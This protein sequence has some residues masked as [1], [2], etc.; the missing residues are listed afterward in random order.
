MIAYVPKC[1]RVFSF[2]GVARS[3]TQKSA[4]IEKLHQVIENTIARRKKVVFMVFTR[5][6]EADGYQSVGVQCVSSKKHKPAS[7]E[8]EN[9]GYSLVMCSDSHIC[10]SGSIFQ[11]IPIHI[12]APS[13][14]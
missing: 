6:A 3:W 7:V 1:N 2:V 14:I 11:V 4:D 8:W 12:F 13:V 9:K 5:D 10:T